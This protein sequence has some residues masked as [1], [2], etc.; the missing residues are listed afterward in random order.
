[1]T[2]A[3]MS[4]SFATRPDANAGEAFLAALESAELDDEPYTEE[5]R[6]AAHAGWEAYLRGESRP[7]DEVRRSL[8]DEHSDRDESSLGTTS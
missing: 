4:D 1:M 3:G 2:E 5:D 8:F 7:W 6:A